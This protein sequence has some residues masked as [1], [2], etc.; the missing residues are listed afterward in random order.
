MH[1]GC[2]S[3]AAL[4]ACRAS[5]GSYPQGY[6]GGQLSPEQKLVSR[7]QVPV[8]QAPKERLLCGT[9]LTALARIADIEADV[10]SDHVK[11]CAAAKSEHGTLAMLGGSPNPAHWDS[12]PIID[13]VVEAKA[14]FPG[15]FDGLLQAVEQHLLATKGAGKRACPQAIA[16]LSIVPKL[17]PVSFPKEC[18]RR[19]LLWAPLEASSDREFLPARCASMIA[20][21]CMYP[22][23]VVL[24]VVKVWCNGVPTN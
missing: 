3:S 16:Y 11:Q 2:S 12:R 19:V 20:T 13:N 14:G 4:L 5:S 17:F 18:A 23:S 21:L 24:S 6:G 9:L 8:H 1:R 10:T 7:A 15:M 22:K